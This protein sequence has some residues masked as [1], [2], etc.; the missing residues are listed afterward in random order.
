[1]DE[2]YR[3]LGREH[4]ADLERH[5]DK[6]RC[7]SETPVGRPGR[8][9]RPSSLIRNFAASI[10]EIARRFSPHQG[11]ARRGSQA[12]PEESLQGYD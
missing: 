6:W 2:T 12:R 3:M 8:A 5:A 11:S 1:M 10:A 7:A 9:V 4:Q